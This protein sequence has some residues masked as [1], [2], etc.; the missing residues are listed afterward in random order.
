MA[1]TRST[2]AAANSNHDVTVEIPDSVTSNAYIY[3]SIS[4]DG[5]VI[6]HERLEDYLNIR[7]PAQR[8]DRAMTWGQLG[9]GYC[10]FALGCI[11]AIIKPWF[12]LAQPWSSLYN[13]GL[14]NFFLYAGMAFYSFATK[15]LHDIADALRNQG[16]GYIVLGLMT[17]T[18]KVFLFSVP[19]AVIG[20]GAGF[21][22]EAVR[23]AY[24]N[25]IK[26][27]PAL[28]VLTSEPMLRITAALISPWIF[29]ATEK[30]FHSKF[31]PHNQKYNATPALHPLQ[32][33]STLGFAVYDATTIYAFVKI[34]IEEYGK[35]NVVE[36]ALHHPYFISGVL[37][38]YIFLKYGSDPY[39]F[40][41]HPLTGPPPFEMVVAHDEMTIVEIEPPQLMLIENRNSD[42]NADMPNVFDTYQSAQGAATFGSR[43]EARCDSVKAAFVVGACSVVSM[44][45]GFATDILATYIVGDAALLSDFTW[46]VIVALP[47]AVTAVTQIG[48]L[49]AAPKAIRCWASLFH[50][51]DE[52][53]IIPTDSL[54]VGSDD[55]INP[56]PAEPAVVTPMPE[57][58][59]NNNK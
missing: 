55:E 25:E 34:M 6:H 54:L 16:R 19:S 46:K 56:A 36:A 42:L 2:Q 23:N 14:V 4:S 20:L 28:L 13:W 49:Y 57:R 9:V 5:E 24:E 45:A 17:S 47:C 7:P 43:A 44:G 1:N 33:V 35:E 50:S 10:R 30:Y 21:A 32:R 52:G 38:L 39:T 8:S 3:R 26:E 40:G 15:D 53:D 48:L 22:V 31:P 37:P 59:N 58:Q 11:T 41:P 51:D 27:N 12:E 18:G 29:I